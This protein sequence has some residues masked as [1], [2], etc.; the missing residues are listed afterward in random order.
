MVKESRRRVG[1]AETQEP[2]ATAAIC[3]IP[4]APAHRYD[5][6]RSFAPPHCPRSEGCGSDEALRFSDATLAERN[7]SCVA[8][9]TAT[10]NP[11]SYGSTIISTG[12]PVTWI[13]TS[14]L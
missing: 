7:R 9:E 3:A 6:R 4:D 13:G 5:C 14:G 1:R 12:A 11:R 8:S 10:A 2:H